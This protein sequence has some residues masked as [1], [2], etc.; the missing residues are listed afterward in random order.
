[1]NLKDF[2]IFQDASIKEAL[3]A[4]E[5]NAHGV[6]FIVDKFDSV[7]GIAT[8]GD[9]RRKL[10]N[11]INVESSISLCA[12]TDFYWANESV[13]RESLIKKLDEKLKII[14]ILGED[15]KLI[16]IVTNDSF[17]TLDEEAIYVRSKSPV[18]I[19][20]G[21][22]GSDL[23]H[24]FSGDIGA[25]INTTI[26]FYSHATLRIRADKKILIK[27]L[28][29]KDS[30]QA[31]NF[32]EL[33]KPKEGFGLI[34]AVIKTI[35]PN[36]G[37]EL[38]LYSDFPMSSGLGGSA[39]VAA[40]I[41]GCFNELRQDQWGLHELAELAYQAERLYQGIEGGWQDQYATVFGGFNFME[42][43]MEQN[44]V[45][46]LRLTST[47]L[48]ELEESLIL[49][50]TNTTHN[51]GNIHSD[52]RKQMKNEEI[53]K[54]VQANVKL[55]FDMRDQLLR[56]R[57]NEFGHSLNKA[58]RFK[59]ELSSQITNSQLDKIYDDALN[60]GAIGGKLLGAGGGGY[61]IFFVPHSKK[62]SLIEHLNQNGLHP[63]PF[64]FESKG[65]QSWKVREP[66]I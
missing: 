4:I 40:S 54:L 63:R 62:L 38:D 53:K 37:F 27:S 1:M 10:L 6:I 56:G 30:I 21:G 60:H 44:L 5:E 45:H 46:P 50:D 22:G 16:D 33:M 65:L 58:W 59:R 25:V 32:E 55:C 36:F 61:F 39:V 35:A 52:Q 26:S 57:L 14:P 23:T 13:S 64:R 3:Q 43:K 31:N 15:N 66:K 47:N 42:F 28:D 12:N 2:L 20:F 18:R 8:D 51:S 49:C 19:S 9:I 11:N 48:L 17:P 24:Y 7:F 34:Q 41:L 29:L